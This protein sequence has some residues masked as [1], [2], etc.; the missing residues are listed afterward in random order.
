[1]YI[2]IDVGGTNTVGVLMENKKLSCHIKKKTAKSDFGNFIIDFIQELKGNEKIESI[3]LGVPG[4]LNETKSTVITSPNLRNIENIELQKLIS[5]KFSAKVFIENDANCFVWGEYILGAGKSFDN[6][7]G[8]TLGSGLG[9]GVIIDG[10]LFNGAH[11]AASE[12]GHH[13]IKANGIKCHCGN[14]G[15]WEQYASSQFFFRQTGMS[16]K[17]VYE[18]AKGGDEKALRV[19]KYFGYWLGIGIANI[20]NILDPEAIIMGGNI[21]NAWNYFIKETKKNAQLN[22]F[23]SVAAKKVKIL[24]SKLGY[25]AGAIGAANLFKK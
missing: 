1:M 17:T 19:W 25:R 11:G 10:E 24:K 5:E 23:S 16:P 6:I 2:G 20:V 9:S 7:V 8:L 21:T 4:V 13:I 15:C 22:I 3:G 14:R 18:K 12:F